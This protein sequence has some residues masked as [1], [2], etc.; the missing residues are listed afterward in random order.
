MHKLK[1]AEGGMD[2][3]ML[4][5]MKAMTDQNK[6]LKRMYRFH[7]NALRGLWIELLNG[8]ANPK[9][10]VVITGPK[11]S[12]PLFVVGQKLE[13]YRLIT[14]SQENHNRNFI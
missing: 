12:V 3:A 6:R 1:Q 4:S 11:I 10:F 7:Q 13:E 8:A 2:V 5:E 14:F 9:R